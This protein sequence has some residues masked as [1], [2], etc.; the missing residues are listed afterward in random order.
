M[1]HQQASLLR[2][3]KLSLAGWVS[4]LSVSAI[5]S[6]NAQDVMLMAD[7]TDARMEEIYV[8]G[9]KA[10]RS[11]KDTTSSV[12]VVSEEELASMQKQS[13]SNLVSDIPNVV[14]LSG[15]VP[16]IRGVSGNGS[17]GGFNSIT[18]GAKSRVSIL[19]DGVAEP[20]VADFTG[21]SG[22]WDI[23]QIEVFRGPQS[24][25][26]GRNS[27]AGSMNIKTND[28][29]FEPEGAVRVGYRNQDSYIDTSAVLSGPIVDEQLA[30][31]IS[32]QRLDADTIT[33]DEGFA[34]RSPNYDLD[35]IET[36]R[37]RAKLKWK[38]SD[39]FSTQ[40]SHST[41]DEQGD[42]GRIYYRATNLEDRDRIFFRDITTE[43][44]TTSLRMDYLISEFVSFD[45]VVATMDYKWGFDTYEPT[46]E[47]EQ[48]MLFD[49]TN[50][51]ID[52]K[53]SFGQSGDATSGFLGLAYF[54]R[55][56]TVDSEGASVYTGDDQSS[57]A[58]VYGEITQRLTDSWDI[59]AGARV[60]QEEQE[61]R[62]IFRAID[63]VLEEENT[64]FLPKLALKY[65]ANESTTL[66]LSVRKGYNAPGGALNSAA[67]QYYYYDEESVIT[68][69][70]STRT[71]M[72]DSMLSIS[73]NVFYNQYEGY[74][75]LSSTRFI[76]NMPEVETY[77]AEV[78][79][80]AQLSE[81]VELSAG[82]GLLSSEITDPG[83]DYSAVEGNELNSAPELT[84]NV[85]A[86]YYFSDTAHIGI[87]A[88]YVGEY[89]GDFT[90]TPERVA[91]DY[92][93]VR[94]NGQV[95][96]Q[97]WTL[98]AFVNNVF[99]KEAFTAQEPVGG[100]YPDG[101]VAIVAPR[102]VG[103]SVTYKF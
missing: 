102:N 46:P 67:Q 7:R 90:N 13:L 101:Y 11:L 80:N 93:L 51:S 18:G 12:A 31:R 41:L 49:E 10:K 50:H 76:V 38:L 68:Y 29:T 48:Q 73:S 30:G 82:L 22:L 34:E 69:E 52:A 4:L 26:N 40:L 25:S 28:P 85:K 44:S 103:V 78:S 59:T 35:K 95:E 86:T 94:L 5:N 65:H 62:F 83:E 91:G 36:T 47:A 56:H 39:K 96:L 58:S 8:T 55:D 54:E 14:A 21:D 61:R 16:D 43:S 81:H 57:S 45:M 37:V 32:V 20:F 98:G 15:A 64:I 84:S 99:D 19:V 74:Q 75:A 87:A 71:S 42:T 100:R 60:E 77:G 23:Q 3:R 63:A 9:E 6:A 17:A 89:F 1:S 24:T 27:I 33:G 97:G 88:N 66:G 2:F 70:F 72:M 92:T 53:I 79:F